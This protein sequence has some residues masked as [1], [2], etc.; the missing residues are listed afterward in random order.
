MIPIGGSVNRDIK[1]SMWSYLPNYYSDSHVVDEIL[2]VD[3]DELETYN[4]D[5]VDM[6]NQFFIDT[7]TWG[8]DHWEK[9]C[10]LPINPKNKTYDQRR[11][12]VKG[13]IRGIGVVNVAFVKNIAES[14]TNGE[15]DVT[16]YSKNMI[17]LA[18]NT[19]TAGYI[20]NTGATIATSGVT[21]TQSPTIITVD[22]SAAGSGQDTNAGIV[23]DYIELNTSIDHIS[24]SSNP[25]RTGDVAYL[26]LTF[27]DV[28]HNFIVRNLSALNAT[29]LPDMAVPS[30]AKYVKWNI[31]FH[32]NTNIQ[33]SPQL[34]KGTVCT[35]FEPRYDYTVGIT[36]IGARGV[37]NDIQSLEDALR[38]FIPAHLGINYI[39]TY[40]SWDQFEAHNYTFD[41]IDIMTWD[42]VEKSS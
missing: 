7:A 11:S 37:P 1:K 41:N 38:N 6:L 10:G 42:S 27:Y 31:R 36:F 29:T 18:T 22:T 15:V 4:S 2:R 40:V 26:S 8:L 28:N 32:I 3:A 34:E 35:T 14:F 9:I 20:D 25:A 5:V 13:K 39:F 33:I 17:N 30:G 16:E 19:F 12:I 24:L 21:L 23:S